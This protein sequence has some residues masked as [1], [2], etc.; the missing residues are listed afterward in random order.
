M[1]KYAVAV[2]GSI[3]MFLGL[4][5]CGGEIPPV[6]EPLTVEA[7]LEVDKDFYVRNKPETVVVDYNVELIDESGTVG[8]KEMDVRVDLFRFDAATREFVFEQT[9]QESLG[10]LVNCNQVYEGSTSWVYD[11]QADA[12]TY[13][14]I[15]K[16]AM[17]GSSFST[18][19]D[20][21][22]I[23]KSTG[24]PKGH[25]KRDLKK[26]A[27]VEKLITR[28]DGYYAVYEAAKE[29][30]LIVGNELVVIH[31]EVMTVEEAVTMA[32][33]LRLSA[34][35]DSEEAMA[36]FDSQ[37]YETSFTLAKA[38]ARQVHQ[39]LT[40]YHALLAQARDAEAMAKRRWQNGR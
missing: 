29:D 34:V 11:R 26:I 40:I 28:L 37:D 31:E 23:W 1:K 16:V 38:A 32:D 24:A 9:L 2:F 21:F 13:K 36:Y 5:G 6:I 20:I 25:A 35:G 12:T 14:I 27:Q 18:A 33:D 15:L 30:G 4:F 7:A 17:D 39:S 10:E 22:V 19:G 8:A 3:L